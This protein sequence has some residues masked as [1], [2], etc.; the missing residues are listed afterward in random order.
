[1]E[2]LTKVE[3]RIMMIF[4]KLKK[5]FV[6]D[7]LAEL[8][9]PKP[10]YN[11]ISSVTRILAKKGYLKFKSYGNTYEYS[12]AV[13]QANYQKLKL[14]RIISSHFGNSPAALLSFII[15]EEKLSKEEI[16]K[17]KEIINKIK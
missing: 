5:A 7:I 9:D 1:M 2:E 3:E 17:L 12:P 4:W 6:K 11:T 10:P 14:K 13:S 16:K 15:N 8:P